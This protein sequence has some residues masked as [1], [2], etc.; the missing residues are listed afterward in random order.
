[1]LEKV[2]NLAYRLELPSIIRIH[3]VISVVQLKPAFEKDP[4][5]RILKQPIPPVE[6]DND[7]VDPEFA[8]KYLL[9]KIKRLINRRG[10][11]KNIKYLVY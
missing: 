8:A 3:P 5:T 2:G 1:M 6:E 4:Y 11:G 9:Y 10:L 7:T